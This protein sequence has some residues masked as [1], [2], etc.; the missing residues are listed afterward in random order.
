MSQFPNQQGGYPPP[1]PVNPP[2]KSHAIASMVLGIVGLALGYWIPIV[3]LAI[4]VV[5]LV[6]ASS[7]KKQGFRGGI[8]TAGLVMNI[9]A[10]V[11]GGIMTACYCVACAA[12]P[13]AVPFM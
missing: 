5:G 6:L 8:L 12:I 1:M 2:G 13:F 10:L 3:G 11:F 9:I 4:P 7:A